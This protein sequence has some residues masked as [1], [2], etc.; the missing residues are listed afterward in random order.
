LKATI[1][2]E[3]EDRA[4]AKKVVREKNEGGGQERGKGKKVLADRQTGEDVP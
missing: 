4:R 3:I 2:Y 1:I